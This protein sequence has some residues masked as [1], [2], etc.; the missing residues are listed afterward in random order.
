[1]LETEMRKRDLASGRWGRGAR[2]F[3]LLELVVSL[4]LLTVGLI[5]VAGVYVPVSREAEEIEVESRVLEEA[6]L[7]LEEISAVAPSFLKTTYDDKT[8]AIDGVEG[9]GPSGETLR[10]RVD[11]SDPRLLGV[12]VD[13]DWLVR[14]DAFHLS[15]ETKVYNPDG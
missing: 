4:T 10:V 7:R 5:S 13:A 2:G 9:A 6:R 3:T 12:T 11:S 1:M 14:G 8:F 15:I